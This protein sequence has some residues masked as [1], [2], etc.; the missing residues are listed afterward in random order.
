MLCQCLSGAVNVLL[1]TLIAKS[2][3]AVIRD[4][5]AQ[6][7]GYAGRL[8]I[9]IRRDLQKQKKPNRPING[10][11]SRFFKIEAA[12]GYN[13]DITSSLNSAAVKKAGLKDVRFHDL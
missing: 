7:G 6:K 11:I 10:G 2:A 3:S 12:C 13:H 4:P 8:H 9:H 5:Q 1:S